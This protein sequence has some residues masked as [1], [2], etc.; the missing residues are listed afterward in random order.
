M[1]K[2]PKKSSLTEDLK[3]AKNVDLITLP[4]SITGTNCSNC[5]YFKDNF[6]INEK[7]NQPVTK[8]ECCALWDAKGTIRAWETNKK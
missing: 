5:E 2:P 4:P 8:R 3:K 6:C 1:N 7:V